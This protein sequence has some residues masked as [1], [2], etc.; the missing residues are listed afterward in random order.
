MSL[1]VGLIAITVLGQLSLG[2]AAHADKYQAGRCA[3]GEAKPISLTRTVHVLEANGYKVMMRPENCGKDVPDIV[4]GLNAVPKSDS[5]ALVICDIRLRPIYGNG[6]HR[7][8]RRGLVQDNVM[9]G[10]YPGSKK[11]AAAEEKKLFTVVR[12]LAVR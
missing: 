9:C 12:Q 3:S 6:F 5:Q 4:M 8:G 10:V 11:R 7:I 1:G 2:C